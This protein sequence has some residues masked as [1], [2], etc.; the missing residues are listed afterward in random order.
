MDFIEIT[1][2]GGGF[3]VRI[4][5][6]APFPLSKML[7]MFLL[8]ICLDNDASSGE[9]RD[10][11]VGWKSRDDLA[12]SMG[13]RFAAGAKKKGTDFKGYYDAHDVAEWS[14]QLKKALKANDTN[15]RATLSKLIQSSRKGGVRFSLTRVAAARLSQRLDA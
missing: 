5:N 7:G 6:N 12:A 8:L 14:Y 9:P 4:E 15:P 13:K 1:R 11:L 3:L 2:S 10:H